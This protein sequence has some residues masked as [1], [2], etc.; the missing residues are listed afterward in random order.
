[1]SGRRKWRSLLGWSVEN[2]CSD[3]GGEFMG[4]KITSRK[5]EWSTSYYLNCSGLR[6]FELPLIIIWN[7]SPIAYIHVP[8]MKDRNWMPRFVSASIWVT[9]Q[10]GR[11]IDCIP[12]SQSSYSRVIHNQDVRFNELGPGVERESFTNMLGENLQL[13]ICYWHLELRKPYG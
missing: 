5:K 12:Y 2:L 8:K 1:M 6:P 9:P 10:I 7:W 13:N 4:L 3:N 11:G